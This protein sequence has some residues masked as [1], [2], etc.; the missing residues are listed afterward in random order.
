VTTLG[1]KATL[2]AKLDA[3][4]KQ[5]YAGQVVGA[6][7]GG[8]AAAGEMTEEE[9]RLV[10]E[11]VLQENVALAARMAAMRKKDGAAVAQPPHNYR[12]PIT[13][14][15]MDDPVFAMDGHTYEREAIATWFQMHD[16]SPLTRAVIPPTLV[17]NVNLRSQI[18][19]WG[20]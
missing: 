8:A 1:A 2:M 9:R 19:S 3:V 18:A 20:Q 13:T 11:Q 14:E 6:G 16:T 5:H 10:L 15:I 17:P 4:K 7:G 12:C